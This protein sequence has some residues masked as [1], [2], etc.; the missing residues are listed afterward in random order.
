MAYAAAPPP[1]CGPCGTYAS[2]DPAQLN[3]AVCGSELPRRFPSLPPLARR[4]APPSMPVVCG[5]AMLSMERIRRLAV[6][7]SHLTTRVALSG[8]MLDVELWVLETHPTE[9]LALP[10]TIGVA[11]IPPRAIAMRSDAFV[12][13]RAREPA[14]CRVAH[15]G[16]MRG[17]EVGLRLQYADATHEHRT[18]IV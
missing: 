5:T 7:A 15:H 16:A 17:S 6:T 9:G 11:V 12:E 10:A 13:L 18:T 14:S 8:D 3:C 2:P 4:D 1:R